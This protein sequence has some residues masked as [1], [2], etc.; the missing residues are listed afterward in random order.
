MQALAGRGRESVVPL[1]SKLPLS[2]LTSVLTLS[3]DQLL[4]EARGT[5][6]PAST[7]RAATPIGPARAAAGRRGALAEFQLACHMTTAAF[8]AASGVGRSVGRWA[9]RW[10]LGAALSELQPAQIIPR[11]VPT[12]ANCCKTAKFVAQLGF[13]A[14]IYIGYTRICLASLA[15]TCWFDLSLVLWVRRSLYYHYAIEGAALLAPPDPRSRSPATEQREL[16]AQ[17]APCR[18]L[19]PAEA[20]LPPLQA[21]ATGGAHLSKLLHSDLDTLTMGNVMNGSPR[22]WL[23]LIS[24]VWKTAVVLKLLDRVRGPRSRSGRASLHH[25]GESG[26][27]HRPP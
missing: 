18:S 23:H 8:N 5:L 7:A 17:P 12:A 15:L 20:R 14:V 19:R 3:D 22:L 9:Q 16:S 26:H 13:D 2:W 27:L 11:T 24:T 25:S 6:S 21:N 1:P 4:P 10:A